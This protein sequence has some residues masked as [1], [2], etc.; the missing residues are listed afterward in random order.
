MFGAPG[1]GK[2]VLA[3]DLAAHLAA[4]RSWLGRDVEQCAVAYA[5]VERAS[6]TKRRLAAWRKHH[7]IEDLPL[8]I[9]DG[10]VDLRAGKADS[11]EL[12]EKVREIGN[13]FD[14]TVGL[15]VIDTVSRAL[16]GGDENG[17][18]DMGAL[19]A[20]AAMIQAETGASVLLIHHIPADGTQR[21]R[22]HGALL[23]AVDVSLSVEKHAA[24]RTATIDK[25]N[26][27]EEGERVTFDLEGVQIADDGTTAPVV[28]ASSVPVTVAS[29]KWLPDRVKNA[30]DF[31]DMCVDGKLLAN[32]HGMPDSTRV[33]PVDQW[34]EA[35]YTRG[36][37]DREHKNPR[38]DFRRVK[39]A[40]Q[41][42]KLAAEIDSQIWAV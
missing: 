28:V 14:Q 39:D 29:R 33:V 3:S 18:K 5:A 24:G 1:S 27:G 40:L 38:E 23:G 35:L 17:P 2:S 7:G 22:G 15:I 32:G 6:L 36:V 11:R 42:R 4:G 13:I 9:V 19:V 30:L 37:L 31:R 34:R 41:A 20:N 12:I 10:T 8:G 25:A 16:N 26:D 21:M